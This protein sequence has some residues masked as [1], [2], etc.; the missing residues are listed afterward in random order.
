MH[1]DCGPYR[2]IDKRTRVKDI[3]SLEAT[4]M[5]YGM[6]IFQINPLILTSCQMKKIECTMLYC[7]SG[8]LMHENHKKNGFCRYSLRR[9][10]ECTG[11][12]HYYFFLFLLDLLI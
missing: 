11:F 4:Q 6:H 8:T 7:L 5:Q 10:D 2:V 9:H 12:V 3:E 1:V